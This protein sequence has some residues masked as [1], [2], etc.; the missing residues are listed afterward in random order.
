[1]NERFQSLDVD[2]INNDFM[3]DIN[4]P[5]IQRSSLNRINK[6]ALSQDNL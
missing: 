1:M 6:N 3:L 5:Q 4:Q 2:D